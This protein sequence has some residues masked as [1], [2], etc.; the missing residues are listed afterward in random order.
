[1]LISCVVATLVSSSRTTN[2]G[3]ILLPS[4]V[5]V[6]L[7]FLPTCCKS[8]LGIPS[9]TSNLTGFANYMSR[10]L[11]NPEEHGIYIIDRRHRPFGESK[12]QLAGCLWRFCCQS[13]RQRIE[14]YLL[15]LLGTKNFSKGIALRSSLN[16][17]TGPLCTCNMPRPVAWLQR[18]L[19][20]WNCLCQTLALPRRF[21][22]LRQV[23][24]LVVTFNQHVSS[25]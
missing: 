5:L 17:L 3:A 10:R 22:K 9:V 7:T 13:Q 8:H 15:N 24:Q 12:E 2:L 21:K 1:M 19:L 14:V 25:L 4:A 23:V 16:S 18:R 6:V 20:A 11:S